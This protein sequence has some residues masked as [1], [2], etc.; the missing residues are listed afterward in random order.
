M[1]IWIKTKLSDKS[2]AEIDAG[3]S[4]V[5]LLG[6][7]ETKI[8]QGIIR[9]S[10]IKPLSDG[11]PIFRLAGLPVDIEPII[12]DAKLTTTDFILLTDE[13]VLIEQR[14]KRVEGISQLAI[15]RGEIAQVDMKPARG[16]D[17]WM[18]E[19]CDCA[20]PEV[21]AIAKAN[22]L[23]PHSR[24]DIQMPSHGK[25]VLQDQENYLMSQ[26]SEKKGMSR[27]MWD[28]E[29]VKS[30]KYSKGIDIEKDVIDGKGAAHEFIL[31]RLRTKS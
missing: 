7:H 15:Q 8:E 25:Q 19:G 2:K 4:N 17:D 26:I 27:S 10:I 9:T 3:E 18:H 28:S 31:S 24:A 29:A 1:K 30:G 13:E 14:T 20:D 11:K 22:G 21:D 16:R 5:P 23:D 6:G 12:T